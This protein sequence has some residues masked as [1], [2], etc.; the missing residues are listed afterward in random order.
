[1]K[2]VVI[3]GGPG[4][5]VAAIRAAQLGAEVTLVEKKYIGGT[6]LNVGC[7]PT[8]VLLHT[9]ELYTTLAKESKKLGI[10]I[11]KLDIDW[12]KLQQRKKVVVGQLIGGVNML[13]KSN[14]VKV[15]MGKASFLNAN[16]LEVQQE[17]GKKATVD[18][19]YAIIATGSKPFILP[20]PGVDLEGVITSDEALSLEE[21][22]KS[23]LVIGGGVIGSE[24][25]S[26]YS[27][28]GTKV[29]IVEA[30]PNIV[31]T[32]DQE[33]TDYL[34]EAL[35]KAG[36]DICT[37]T[38]VEGIEKTKTGLRV[39]A[40]SK[41]GSKSFEVEKVLLA[42]GR[43][44]VTENMGLEKI[45]IKLNK[46]KIITNKKFQTNISNIYAIGDCRG[47]IM[48]AHVASAEGIVA[49]EGIMGKAS[50]IDFKTIPY[51]VYTKPELA[52]VGMTEKQAKEK[53]YE[54]KTGKF[55]LYANGKSLIMG[56]A[57]G[58]VKY[59]VD[60]KTEEILGLHMAG[61]RATELI[62]EGALALRLE[63]TIEEIATTIH[64]HPTVGESLHEA[65][66]AVHNMA[67]H[68][69]K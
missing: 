13:L 23:M 17:E 66:H 24:F 53:G 60:A 32:M 39:K 55:P 61:P 16:Q 33:V 38:K 14:K 10:K 31:A 27:S 65:V 34:V 44:P 18:F 29:T 64:A 52:A 3:G 22:P 30:L 12:K 45:G 46:D 62:V 6:C 20:I 19:D 49:V 5:Y 7:I 9:A 21:I 47:E 28:M 42:I 56:E 37:D 4:G 2:V 58:V 36:V 50:K 54:T 51:A 48:L 40:V 35:K 15:I 43:K 59:V 1:M 26:V 68:L 63:A 8:K 11:E 25:A 57:K 69:P 67:I 41:E